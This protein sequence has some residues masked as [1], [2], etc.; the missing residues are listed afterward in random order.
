MA[1]LLLLVRALQLI[2]GGLQLVLDLVEMADLVLS[3]LEVLLGLGS[4]L[5]DVLL[6][7][8]ELVDDLILVG[9]LIIQALDGMVTVGLLLL[10]LLDGDIDVVNVLLDGHNLLLK[11]LLV[12]HGVLASLLPLGELVLGSHKLVLVVSNL[13]GGLGLLLVVH[14]QVTL[15]LLQLGHQS[16]LLLLDGLIL[17][18]KPGLGVQLV[19]VHTIGGVGLLLKKPELLLRVG[20]ANER[21]SLLDDDK[22]SPLS[23]RQVLPEVPLGNSDQLSLISLLLVDRSTD[24]LED[25]SLDL[26]DP[27]DDEVI[28]SLLK[29]G[30]S[31]GSEE[32][33]GVSQPVSLPAEADLVHE[34]IGGSLVVAGAGNLGL[35]QASVPH[36]EVRVQHP[37][38]ETSHTDPDA[39]QHTVTGQLVH[40]QRRLNLPRLLVGVGHK[41]ANKVGSA[42][43]EGGHQL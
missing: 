36:L 41:A 3:H 10:Q 32:D 31:T 2:K 39:L 9:D 11:D 1:A 18:Q 22:P 27:F 33:K 24:P 26:A 21:T 38:G 28:T 4:I 13:G 15:L 19:L 5:A 43:V 37:V 6:L 17:L 8:V 14:G 16:L 20:H 29:T 35:A 40:D 34:S 7:L 25:F 23:H 30:E 42:V 12:L